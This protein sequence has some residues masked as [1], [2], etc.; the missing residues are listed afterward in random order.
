M[1]IETVTAFIENT[2]YDMASAWNYDEVLALAGRGLPTESFLRDQEP[3]LKG[4]QHRLWMRWF[5]EG[6]VSPHR[7]ATD[8]TIDRL[9]VLESAF[10]RVTS[11]YAGI[12][13][14]RRQ[15]LAEAVTNHIFATVSLL[16]A[17]AKRDYADLATRH[18][19]VAAA[20]PPRCYICGYAFS[21]EALEAF[22]KVRGRAPISLPPLLDVFRP[23]G[24]VERDVKIEIEHVV[25]VAAG[26]TGKANLRLACGWCNKYKSD[27][28]SIYEAPFMPP[29]TTSFHIGSHRLN[30]LPS[31]FWVIRMLALRGKCQHV[32]GCNRTV[33]NAELFVSLTDW[34]G[35]PNPTNLV[36]H[37]HEHDPICI[38]RMQSRVLVEKLWRERKS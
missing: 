24:L 34:T 35:S 11:L 18:A 33:A 29:R 10:K 25:P 28:V 22:L 8:P 4:D 23:R 26:G 27:R 7:I 30:E 2:P 37:C 32:D 36:V 3:L 21:R 15:K 5:L 14:D 9:D 31:P 19:L 20:S 13:L 38:D 16:R 6:L 12:D 1:S 17:A